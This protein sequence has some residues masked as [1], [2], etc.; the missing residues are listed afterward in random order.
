MPGSVRAI[1]RTL[2]PVRGRGRVPLSKRR[3]PGHPEF[4]PT[5]TPTLSRLE[6]RITDSIVDV[7]D[8]IPHESLLEAVVSGDVAEYGRVVLD[9]LAAR[10]D[11]IERALMDAFVASGDAAAIEIGNDLA[12]AYRRVGKSV[13]KADAPLPSDVALRFRFDRTDPRAVDWVRRESGAMITNMVRS[14]QEAI[15]TIIDASFSAQQTVQQTGSGIFAQLRT[16]TPSAGAREFADTL[17]SNLNGLTARYEQAVINRVQSLGDDLAARGVTGTKALDQMRKEGDR[18]AE[19]LR[20][21]RSKT[22]ART[23]RMRAHN[24]A[25]LLSFQQAVDSG[26]ASAEYSRKQWKTG[27]FDVCPVCVAMQGAESKVNEAFTLPNGS[28][29]EA[30]PAHPNCR[31]TMTMRTDTRLYDPPQ[32][33]GTGTPGDPFRT[34]PRDFS[35]AGRRAAAQGLPTPPTPAAPTS[36]SPAQQPQ[37]MTFSDQGM[38][39]D[40]AAR[41]LSDNVSQASMTPDQQMLQAWYRGGGYGDINRTLRGRW[42]QY[43]DPNRPLF[44]AGTGHEEKK[45]LMRW[46]R[47]QVDEADEIFEVDGAYVRTTRDSK[48]TTAQLV[49]DRLDDLDA[50]ASSTMQRD[51]TLFRGLKGDLGDLSPGDLI[52]DEGFMSTTLVRNVAAKFAKGRGDT[53]L[54]INARAGQRVV[55]IGGKWESEL[56]LPR[57]TT[58]RIVNVDR[59]GKQVVIDAVI[60]AT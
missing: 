45:P 41:W 39:K 22:I 60:E 15:R 38:T 53:I 14:E 17:G 2:D 43:N 35:D 57:G 55:N 27:P 5:D 33:L 44:R 7:V 6:E 10:S 47:S 11:A 8:S 23:E 26:I 29:V 12:R 56:V 34:T 40:D 13:T 28:Q 51:V 36:T 37:S 24:Q 49:T 46:L 30:P 9:T 50:L 48:L 19:R 20:R 16:V 18:Y 31:C 3:T 21:A 52:R 42:G 54:R 32:N 25:R 1:R 4:R 58:I 59:T